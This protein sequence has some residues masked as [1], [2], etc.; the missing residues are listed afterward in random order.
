MPIFLCTKKGTI[1][2]ESERGGLWSVFIKG[3]YCV[4]KA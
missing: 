1:L 2:T 4:N 3:T